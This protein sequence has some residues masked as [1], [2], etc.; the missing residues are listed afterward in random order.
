MGCG[1]GPGCNGL[2]PSSPRCDPAC[3]PGPLGPSPGL[4][5]P[6]T[7]RSDCGCWV[8]IRWLEALLGPESTVAS[9]GP[10]A[11]LGRRGRGRIAPGRS[12][13]MQE[14]TCAEQSVSARRGEPPARTPPEA[15]F[16][17]ELCMAFWQPAPWAGVLQ[18]SPGPLCSEAP[19]PPVGWAA[20]FVS[21]RALMGLPVA[22]FSVPTR[23]ISQA[24]EPR[25]GTNSGT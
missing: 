23:P 20:F 13:K 10:Q 17:N 5:P 16:G 25:S 19:A 14:A 12:A 15:P 8:R 2:E 24:G 9:A 4:S 6:S 18:A 3:P 22:S 11:P 7:V 1:L 21:C